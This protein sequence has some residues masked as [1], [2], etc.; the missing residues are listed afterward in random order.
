MIM[1]WLIA[2][3]WIGLLLGYLGFHYA[4]QKL[5]QQ[6]ARLQHGYYEN[7]DAID[8][9]YERV[10]WGDGICDDCV[11]DYTGEGVTICDDCIIEEFENLKKELKKSVTPKKKTEKKSTK[12]VLTKKSK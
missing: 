2:I 11:K 5:E 8:D 6:V 1:I 10:V 3:V 4:I 12:K 7:S 9:L